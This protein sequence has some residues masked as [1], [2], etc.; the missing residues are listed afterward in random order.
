MVYPMILPTTVELTEDYQR[1]P[2][3]YQVKT[4]TVLALATLLSACGIGIW[5]QVQPIN[6]SD[7]TASAVGVVLAVTFFTNGLVVG[8]IGC[9]MLW[10]MFQARRTADKPRQVGK[11]KH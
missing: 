3:P 4:G 9:W 6:L 1:N 8:W 10:A 11:A 2:K 7:D 5:L